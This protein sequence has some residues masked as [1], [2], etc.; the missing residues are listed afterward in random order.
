[1]STSNDSSFPL[2]GAPRTVD[3]GEMAEQIA[4]LTAENAQ[5]RAEISRIMELWDRDRM[6]AYS[7]VRQGFPETEE[8]LLAQSKT[9]PTFTGYLDELEREMAVSK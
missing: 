5:L 6:I 8:E 2:N 4:N 7:L 3:H 9:M 1:M